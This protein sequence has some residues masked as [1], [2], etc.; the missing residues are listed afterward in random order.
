MLELGGEPL[1]SRT[2]RLI[3]P[4]GTEVT[5]VGSP[6]RYSPLGLRAIA[7]QKNGVGQGIEAVR[8]PLVGIATSLH[9]TVSPWNLILSCDLPYLTAA[10]FDWLLARAADSKARIVMSRSSHRLELLAAVYRRECAAP[11]ANCST[12]R[13]RVRRARI[14]QTAYGSI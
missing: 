1:I 9:A 13:E 11:I 12:L 14:T 2:A 10:G 7:D 8:T 4:L 5:A 6:E 3:E